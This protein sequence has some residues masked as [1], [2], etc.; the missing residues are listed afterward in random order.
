M[1]K[2]IKRWVRYKNLLKC[3]KCGSRNTEERATD[4]IDYT[5]CEKSV[6]CSGCGV[7]VNY[8]SYGYYQDPETYTGLIKYNW[9]HSKLRGVLRRS[10]K[11]VKRWL[12]V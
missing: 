4:Y 8:W 3:P 10:R 12:G 2:R 9:C 11:R 1:I 5:V 7:E 6:H